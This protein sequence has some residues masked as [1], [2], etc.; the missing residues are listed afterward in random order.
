VDRGSVSE[1][2]NAREREASE[3]NNKLNEGLRSCRAV[4]SNYRALLDKKRRQTP[5][6]DKRDDGEDRS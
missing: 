6:K 3:A 1:N 5:I 4:V 2:D